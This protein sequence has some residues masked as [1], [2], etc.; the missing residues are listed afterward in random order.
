MRY[1]EMTD[2]E[3]SARL[4]TQDRKAFSEIYNRYQKILC[5]HA[6]RMTRDVDLGLDIVQEV[7][8]AIWKNVDQ[9]DPQRPIDRYL[10]SCVVNR[11]INAIRND[12]VRGNH[13]KRLQSHMTNY[14]S[15]DE[16]LIEK[17]LQ[18]W[19]E[20]ELQLLPE[21]MRHTFELS[22]KHQL[23]HK[24]ISRQ[25]GTTEGTVKKQIYYALHVLRT[26]LTT[27]FILLFLVNH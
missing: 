4:V 2:A 15:P 12:K 25:T 8:Y 23:S 27:I 22:R 17:Q 14:P 19:L 11:V 3:L 7:F 1:Q 26:R 18:E 10:F 16:K 9:V 20:H 5:C 21:K 24:E 6:Y 13:L